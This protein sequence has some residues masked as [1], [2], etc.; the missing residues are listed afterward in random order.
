MALLG[1]YTPEFG[2]EAVQ[3]AFK[4]S[5]PVAHVAREGDVNP[6]ILRTWVRQH[7]REHRQ[8][9]GPH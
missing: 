7:E 9:D 5:K 6:E 1:L 8:Q 3:L 2:E 4:I